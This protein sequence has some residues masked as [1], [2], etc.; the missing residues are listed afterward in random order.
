[1]K[2]SF[3]NHIQ[4]YICCEIL[5]VSGDHTTCGF[6]LDSLN[7]MNLAKAI[8]EKV[9]VSCGLILSVIHTITIDVALLNFNCVNDGQGLR[10]NRPYH[11]RN[12]PETISAMH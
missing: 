5:N 3:Y 11:S 2:I 9:Y 4:E 12:I 6:C 1:M 8:F 10:V 7:S